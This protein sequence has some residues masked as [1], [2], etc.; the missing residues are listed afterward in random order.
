MANAISRSLPSRPPEGSRN[1]LEVEVTPTGR[2]IS[3]AAVTAASIRRLRWKREGTRNMHTQPFIPIFFIL[4]AFCLFISFMVIKII[5]R[6]LTW[7]PHQSLHCI[8][9][10]FRKGH[11]C[12]WNFPSVSIMFSS[13][14]VFISDC[15]DFTT[16]AEF[17]ASIIPSRYT[18]PERP[19]NSVACGRIKC[20]IHLTLQGGRQ[21]SGTSHHYTVSRC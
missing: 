15:F 4:V 3:Q 17:Y 16:T 13:L 1:F 12:V 10:S 6:T 5:M 8:H 19:D 21:G 11:F 18:L 14:T 2:C 9:S 7:H 20:T